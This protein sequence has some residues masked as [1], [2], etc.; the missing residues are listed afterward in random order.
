[1]SL[2]LGIQ[3]LPSEKACWNVFS[4]WLHLGLLKHLSIFVTA[5]VLSAHW[6]NLCNT[7][8]P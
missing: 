7:G 3:R 2:H 8:M 4:S 5:S 6:L 1:M